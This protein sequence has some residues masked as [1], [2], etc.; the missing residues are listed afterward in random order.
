[1]REL[2][3]IPTKPDL[4][5]TCGDDQR[6]VLSDAGIVTSIPFWYCRGCKQD[7]DSAGFPPLPPSIRNYPDF[8]E[9][10]HEPLDW[11]LVQF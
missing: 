6:I 7:L 8:E 5:I 3:E 10:E 1:M 4:C 9:E 2:P 11:D